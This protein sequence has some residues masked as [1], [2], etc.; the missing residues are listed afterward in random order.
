MRRENGMKFQWLTLLFTPAPSLNIQV[1]LYQTLFFISVPLIPEW[2]SR[3]KEFCATKSLGKGT[4]LC[5][6]A[7]FNCTANPPMDIRQTRGNVECCLQEEWK[8]PNIGFWLTDVINDASNL[9][10]T[11][12][13]GESKNEY[14]YILK[15]RNLS[16]YSLEIFHDFKRSGDCSR[17]LINLE[18]SVIISPLSLVNSINSIL[19]CLNIRI[20]SK[21]IF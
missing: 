2:N 6:I 18:C 11:T 17:K 16:R 5:F 13:Q 7:D 1:S 15:A 9:C 10:C 14:E 8:E 20:C 19:S 3:D 21:L 4:S 12:R